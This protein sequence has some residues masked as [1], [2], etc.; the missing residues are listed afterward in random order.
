MYYAV[1]FGGRGLGVGPL[2]RYELVAFAQSLFLGDGEQ[3]HV[4]KALEPASE[5][6]AFFVRVFAVLFGLLACGLQGGAP[7]R[8][9]LLP[10]FG[11]GGLGPRYLLSDSFRLRAGGRE[12][13]GKIDGPARQGGL[14][15]GDLSPRFGGLALD[16]PQS[17]PPLPDR[18]HSRARQPRGPVG[19]ICRLVSFARRHPF[20]P[21][22]DL[23][24]PLLARRERRPQLRR[25]TVGVRGRDAGLI[26]S[27]RGRGQLAARS[28]CRIRSRGQRTFL[29]RRFAREGLGFLFAGEDLLARGFHDALA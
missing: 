6:L 22:G 17:V 11:G 28:L 5:G 10:G 14:P 19:K 16:L 15:D 2:G 27:G 9:Y 8:L 23:R 21:A 3:V 20:E 7:L 1:K 29:L 26:R 4:P 18:G 24:L 12:F 13:A 25:P